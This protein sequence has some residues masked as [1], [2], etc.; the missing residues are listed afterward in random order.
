VGESVKKHKT[1]I[2]EAIIA[3]YFATGFKKNV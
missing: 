1:K 3:V 2:V